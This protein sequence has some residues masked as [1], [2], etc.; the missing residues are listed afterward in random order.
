M[1]LFQDLEREVG[2]FHPRSTTVH[3]LR[4]LAP[5]MEDQSDG[6]ADMT[7]GDDTMATESLTAGNKRKLSVIIFCYSTPFIPD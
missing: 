3:T 2:T 4:E 6:D 7:M 5:V 1:S